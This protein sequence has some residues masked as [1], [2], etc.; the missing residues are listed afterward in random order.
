MQREVHNHRKTGA[1]PQCRSLREIGWNLQV[2]QAHLQKHKMGSSIMN[3]QAVS[4]NYHSPSVIPISY[5]FS[6]TVRGKQSG[7]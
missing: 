7:N 5:S 1:M 4:Q 2:N 3:Y 6:G